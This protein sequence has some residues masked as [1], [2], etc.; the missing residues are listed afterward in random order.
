M[1]NNEIIDI[2][3]GT[4]KVAKLCGVTL[5]SVSQ[6]RNNGIPQD[7]LIF[8]AASLEKA[9]DGKYTRKQMFPQTWQDIWTELK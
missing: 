8:L 2:L 1:T 5:P 6:W 3:G 9:S 7:K 4:T